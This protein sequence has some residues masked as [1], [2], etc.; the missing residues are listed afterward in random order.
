MSVTIQLSTPAVRRLIEEDPE[1]K[2]EL[3]RAVVSEI[4]KKTFLHDAAKIMCEINSELVETLKKDSAFVGE[5]QRRLDRAIRD[6]SIRASVTP[7]NETKERFDQ[8]LEPMIQQAIDKV[9][10]SVQGRINE[11]A[12]KAGATIEERI[13]ARVDMITDQMINV[14]VKRRL[15]ERMQQAFALLTP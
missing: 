10:Q 9:K 7:S 12:Q 15:Q 3:Q 6:M 11:A 2:L 5:L 14:E 8:M 1:F 4:V 13:E